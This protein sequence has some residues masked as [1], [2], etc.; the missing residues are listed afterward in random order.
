MSSCIAS[1]VG[2]LRALAQQPAFEPPNV[3][4]LATQSYEQLRP[5]FF[6]PLVAAPLHAPM[7]ASY[8]VLWL[9]DEAS[10][11]RFSLY[12]SATVQ[13]LPPGGD[14]LAPA[15]TQSKL[16]I[17][18]YDQQASTVH[19]ALVPN[20]DLDRFVN[21]EAGRVGRNFKQYAAG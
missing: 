13:Q 5:Q 20:V 16:S 9:E 14:F 17:A 4:G 15:E 18:L 2:M 21:T 11:E 12:V 1:Y 3:S 6:D 8:I 7:G 19:R 10:S